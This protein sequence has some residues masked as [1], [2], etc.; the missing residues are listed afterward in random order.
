MARDYETSRKARDGD[1]ATILEDLKAEIVGL[2]RLVE[3]RLQQLCYTVFLDALC[4][5]HSPGSILQ[6]QL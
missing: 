3:V 1:N 6:L 5:A 2:R 4:S